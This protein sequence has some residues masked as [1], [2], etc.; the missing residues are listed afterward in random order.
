MSSK[1]FKVVINLA[2]LSSDPS[3]GTIGDVYYNTTDGYPKYFNGTAWES[4]SAG[5][6]A[7]VT[8]FNTRTGDITLTGTDVNDA[9]GYTAANAADLGPAIPSQ[10]GNDNKFLQTDGSNLSWV[11]LPTS[12]IG[13]VNLI[14]N[15]PFIVDSTPLGGFDVVE[16]TIYIRQG[17]LYRASKILILTDG[18]STSVDE[19]AIAEIG[20]FMDGVNVTASVD[21]GT[22]VIL[23]VQILDASTNNATVKLIKNLI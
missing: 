22:N 7:G 14:V 20:G 16:Y 6:F 1:K 11:A 4:F 13:P 10:Y 19:Y 2:K 5:G 12:I 15:D 21:G 23:Q 18:I 8:T 9:L 17:S 3:A